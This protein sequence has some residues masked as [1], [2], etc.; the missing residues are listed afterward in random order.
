MSELSVKR[1]LRKILGQQIQKIGYKTGLMGITARLKKHEGA[2]ILMYHSVADSTLSKWIDPDNHVPADIFEL[3]MEYLAHKRKV[4]SLEELTAIVRRGNTPPPGTEVIT[5]DDGYL[6]N[7]S[8]A[9]P[10]LEKYQFPATLF[11]PTGYIDRGEAQWIDQLYSLF[12]F[13]TL[14]TLS[15]ETAPAES[16][17]L[18]DPYQFRT[19]Y[20]MICGELIRSGPEERSVILSR[21][22]DEL[23]PTSMAPGLTMTW[24]D[25]RKLI[26]DY[27]CFDI[28]GHTIE[29]TDL[30][31]VSAEHAET[32]LRMCRDRI[33]T[34]TGINADFFSFCYGRTSDSLRRIAEKVGFEA[35]CGGGGLDP[36]VNSRNDLFRLPR[37]AAPNTMKN[38]DLKT[39]YANSGIWRKMNR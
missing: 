34:E 30:T 24:D 38:F 16:F 12:K 9:A 22:A 4:I 17:D 29:H 10:I 25:V 31:S 21:L 7:L 15:R 11:L 27:S 3:Q 35:A 39:N 20:K 37:I 36:V 19:L 2:L 28:G 18:H 5:F 26:S 13:R 32:E 23:Q 1:R 33:K 14:H 8:V 6:D